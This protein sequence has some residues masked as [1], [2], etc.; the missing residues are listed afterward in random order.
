MPVRT[1]LIDNYDRCARLWSNALSAPRRST[2]T[3]QPRRLAQLHVQLVSPDRGCK[4]RRVRLRRAAA[5]RRTPADPLRRRVATEPP[6]VVYND[7]VSWEELSRV[8]DEGCFD[9]GAC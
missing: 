8:L 1:L 9:S 6:V 7:E 4:R 3:R 2:L 5:P